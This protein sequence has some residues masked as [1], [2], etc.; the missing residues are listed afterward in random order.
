ML[1]SDVTLIDP[2]THR[3]SALINK[4][5]LSSL[6][7]L[8]FTKLREFTTKSELDCAYI[9]SDEVLVV[10][11]ALRKLQKFLQRCEQRK[12]NATSLGYLMNNFDYFIELFDNL[13]STVEHCLEAKAVPKASAYFQSHFALCRE[14]VKFLEKLVLSL[15]PTH[16]ALQC[17]AMMLYGG[18][19]L[20]LEAEKPN[21]RSISLLCLRDKYFAVPQAA[22]VVEYLGLVSEITLKSSV[23]SAKCDCEWSSLSQYLEEL[24]SCAV[25]LEVL[26]LMEAVVNE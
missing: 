9:T 22:L 24:E 20:S 17:H 6:I 21:A 13:D 10:N 3:L 18:G 15:T 23:L 8:L 12:Y 7:E 16:L 25:E 19:N 5:L 11:E 26:N 2:I 1:V 4:P 14:E